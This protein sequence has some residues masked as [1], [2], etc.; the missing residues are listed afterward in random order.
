MKNIIPFEEK[1]LEHLPVN[2]IFKLL[3]FLTERIKIKDKIK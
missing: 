2:K 1:N 3:D